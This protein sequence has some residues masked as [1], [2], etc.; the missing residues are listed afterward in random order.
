MKLQ[1]NQNIEFKSTWDDEYLKWICGFA[2][3]QGGKLFVG[4]DDSG[5]VI[6]IKDA[7]KLAELLPNKIK[8]TLGILVDLSVHIDNEL[9][10]IEI[11]TKPY[12][13]AISLR[14]RYYYRSG[15]SN[16]ELISNAL[17]EFLLKKSGRSW[18]DVVEERATFEDIDPRSVDQFLH[19]AKK[20]GRLA[21]TEDFDIPVLFEKLR[22]TENNNLKRAAIVLFGKDPG[23][24]YNNMK[25]RIGRF[26]KTEVDLK[27][28]ELIEGNLLYSLI[29]VPKMLNY[30]FFVHP[31]E[32]AG[33]KRIEK[34]EY[35]VDALREVLLNAFVHRDYMGTNI[36]IRVYDDKFSIWNEGCLPEGITMDSL[37]K[38]HPSRPRNPVIADVCFKGGYIDSWGRGIQKILNAC[39]EA[40]LPEPFINEQDGGMLVE[41]L[42][43]VFTQENLI[44]IGLNER[45]IK[46]VHF[47]RKKGKI[48][49]A[50]YQKVASISKPTATRDLTELVDKFKIFKKQGSR[51]SG[52]YYELIG[53]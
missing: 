25:T 2:N 48:T 39:K 7:R 30:K 47:V 24:F 40:D 44:K 1:E 3:S 35:P 42:K 26:G 15:S 10:Y 16:H 28:E 21:L 52:T 18:D 4:V 43:D 27:F 8:N 38:Q 45:Q 13:V 50:E 6:G 51:G 29:E 17:T 32:F 41:L 14:G 37:L 36:Q 23:K 31:V 22:L 12:S 34:D 5:N 46:A 20:A 53:S 33:L 49:N 11:I 9:E 19:D